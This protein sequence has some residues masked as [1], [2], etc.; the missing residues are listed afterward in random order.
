[1]NAGVDNQILEKFL[2]GEKLATSEEASAIERVVRL[3]SFEA[4]TLGE[5][6]PNRARRGMWP[7]RRARTAG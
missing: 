4:S 3:L 5:G 1:M 2:R 7:W 6:S